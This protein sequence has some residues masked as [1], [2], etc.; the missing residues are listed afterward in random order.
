MGC[1]PWLPA[2]RPRDRDLLLDVP[3]PP[4]DARNPDF[5]ASVPHSPQEGQRPIHLDTWCSHAVHA[6][7]VR[8][9]LADLAEG[10]W[11]S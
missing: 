3:A 6:N 1:A 4:I 7:T 10:M 11:T 8:E 9:L 5:S 2:T